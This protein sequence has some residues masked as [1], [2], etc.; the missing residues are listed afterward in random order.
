MTIV[1]LERPEAEPE[2]SG[3]FPIM[4]ILGNPLCCIPI[5]LYT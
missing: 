1:N 2:T 5:R 3:K 4:M